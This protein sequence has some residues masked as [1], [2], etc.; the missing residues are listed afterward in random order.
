[1]LD[2]LAA[3][4]IGALV[5][6][7]F[8]LVFLKRDAGGRR[9]ARLGG[10]QHHHSEQGCERCRGSEPVKIIPRVPEGREK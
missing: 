10:C 7:I 3:I 1:M 5:F 4:G 6:I 9:G 2:Y 8:M